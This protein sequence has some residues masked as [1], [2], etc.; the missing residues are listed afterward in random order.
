MHSDIPTSETARVALFYK[1]VIDLAEKFDATQTAYAQTAE[2]MA[3]LISAVN[4]QGVRPEHAKQLIDEAVAVVAA[5]IKDEPTWKARYKKM[6][7]EV[8]FNGYS[9]LAKIVDLQ[10]VA[11]EKEFKQALTEAV[12]KVD[13][14]L[15]IYRTRSRVDRLS[16]SCLQTRSLAKRSDGISRRP[17]CGFNDG[18]SV[19]YQCLSFSASFCSLSSRCCSARKSTSCTSDPGGAHSGVPSPPSDRLTSTRASAH[20]MTDALYPRALLQKR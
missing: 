15:P 2:K 18:V 7:D 19:R 20:K 17:L 13:S 9:A 4:K 14:R 16:L 11:I 8:H 12:A 5:M 10:K 3:D 6:A 1:Q